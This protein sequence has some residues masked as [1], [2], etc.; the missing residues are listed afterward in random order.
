MASGCIDLQGYGPEPLIWIAGQRDC[1][2][3]TAVTTFIL[4]DPIVY[5]SN[6]YDGKPPAL[7]EG[8]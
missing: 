4:T 7:D 6:T 1:D 2:R 8:L 3:G 5:F